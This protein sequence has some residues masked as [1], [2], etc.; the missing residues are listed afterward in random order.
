MIAR[1]A[2]SISAKAPVVNAAPASGSGKATT[3]TTFLASVDTAMS[4]SN[5]VG[6]SIS[7][8]SPSSPIALYG[9]RALH[10][11][12]D[13]DDGDRETLVDSVQDSDASSVQDS[14]ASFS[15]QGADQ[16]EY[17][18]CENH[19]LGADS[20]SPSSKKRLP[21]YDANGDFWDSDFGGEDNGG[22]N[23]DED[24]DEDGGEDVDEDGDFWDFDSV[25]EDNGG[26][27]RDED[28][29]EDGGEDVDED[30]DE[31]GGEDVDDGCEDGGKD[32]GEDGGEDDD[33]D[34]DEDGGEDGDEDGDKDCGENNGDDDED[35]GEDG[36]EDGDED[37]DEDGG[38]DGGDD[39]AE[40]DG[41]D[42]EACDKGKDIG[43]DQ[44]NQKADIRAGLAVAKKQKYTKDEI[45]H[46]V[47]NTYQSSECDKEVVYIGGNISRK[48]K[49]Q[50]ETDM[51]NIRNKQQQ[52]S[53]VSMSK[54]HLYL[55]SY[56]A[57][58]NL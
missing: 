26:I 30:G 40:N 50:R 29:D 4:A 24:S 57:A 16:D 19:F 27:N 3:V 8:L 46:L 49:R 28:S 22:I 32:G 33:E 54:V 43:D 39:G 34:G 58:E 5:A 36:G 9:K 23:R 52:M 20:L 31:D 35:C 10:L 6:E 38:E 56:I 15:E 14:D 41:D 48:Q 44:A 17:E 47:N 12:T 7:R 37:G 45:G 51:E 13:H 21:Q 53:V 18:P 11:G 2:S 25:G 1:S 55:T 42:D